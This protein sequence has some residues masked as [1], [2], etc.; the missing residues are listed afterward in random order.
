M[1]YLSE[2]GSF[3]ENIHSSL[4]K[5]RIFGYKG[6]YFLA[7]STLFVVKTDFW[8]VSFSL[9]LAKHTTKHAELS[10]NQCVFVTP[11]LLERD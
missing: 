10:A 4:S 1:F 11:R 2:L 9:C 5:R 6:T 3:V 8:R 7:K